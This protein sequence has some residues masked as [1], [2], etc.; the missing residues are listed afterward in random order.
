MLNINLRFKVKVK[1]PLCPSIIHVM[2][3]AWE[4][5]QINLH[6]LTSAPNGQLPFKEWALIPVD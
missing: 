2:K 3:E 1:F 5:L 6:I 4:V